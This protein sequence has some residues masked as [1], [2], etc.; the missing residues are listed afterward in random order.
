MSKA[1]EVMVPAEKVVTLKPDD[2]LREAVQK[3]AENKISGA[4]V[5][6]GGKV[7]GV[8]SESDIL[9]F[10]GRALRRRG[11]E[12]TFD[13]EKAEKTKVD[14]IMTKKVVGVGPDTALGDVARIMSRRKINRVVVMDDRMALLGLIARADIIKAARGQFQ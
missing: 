7:V 4:P 1:S 12:V 10:F 9:R 14:S 13:R 2:S 5:V 6:Q 8:I 11:A 3:L